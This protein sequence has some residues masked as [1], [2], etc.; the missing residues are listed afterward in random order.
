M[1]YDPSK[2][3]DTD[4]LSQSQIDLVTN[5]FQANVLTGI[6]HFEYNFTTQAAP[7]DNATSADRGK[8]KQASFV[9]LSD[10][11]TTAAGE[12]ALYGKKINGA[13]ALFSRGESDG[14]VNQMTGP[15]IEGTQGQTV[16][17]GGI[18]VKWGVHTLPGFAATT[19]VTYLTEG[20]T[21]MPNNTF[22]ALTTPRTSTSRLLSSTVLTAA[23]FRVSRSGGSSDIVFFWVAIGD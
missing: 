7:Y 2:P 15:F 9:E 14:A 5:F 8:H 21:D 4:F 23:S 10:D 18:H 13:L 11:P 22:V 6:D 3:L 20:L 1:T 17:P 12:I 16:V 19:T